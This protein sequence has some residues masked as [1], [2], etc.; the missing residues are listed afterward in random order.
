MF[1][2]NTLLAHTDWLPAIGLNIGWRLDGLALIFGLLTTG[3]GLLIILYAA[4]YLGASDPAGQFYSLLMLFMAAMLGI[5]LSDNLLL[6]VFWELTSVSSFLLVGYWAADPQGGAAARAG[7]RMALA[8]TGGGGLALLAGVLL[9][10]QIAGSFELSVLLTRGALVRAHPLYPLALGLILL[11]CFTKSAQWPFYFWLPEAMAAPT[12]ASAYLHSAT[13]VKAGIFLL[14]RLYPVLGGSELF[15]AI[16]ALVGRVTMV[17]GAFLAV[18]RHDLKGLLAYST[19]S[20]LGLIVF[21]IGLDS[22]LSAVAAVFHILNHATFKAAL[23]MTVGII[24]HE[25]GSRG[26]RQLGGL[27]KLMPWTARAGAGGRRRHGRRAAGQRILVQDAVFCRGAGRSPKLC[28]RPGRAA[29]G[30]P[31]RCLRGGLLAALHTRCVF[32]RPAPAP[33]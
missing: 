14:A 11:G 29:A 4:Y 31:G 23:F 27:F 24:D 6:L 18:F 2:G 8:V 25:T 28:L 1:A 22:P 9:L 15:Q 3:V 16:V 12:P 30:Y 21:L 32:Q 19:I 20:H 17:Y 10:G 7:A 33:G 13:M 5:V 26:M